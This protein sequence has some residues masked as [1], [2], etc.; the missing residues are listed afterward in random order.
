MHATINKQELLFALD[1]VVKTSTKHQTLPVLQCV[2]MEAKKGGG[3]TLTTNNLELGV[4]VSLSCTVDETFNVAVPALIFQQTINLVDD[5]DITLVLEKEVLKIKTKRGNTS[6]KPLPHDEFPKIPTLDSKKQS[7]NGKLLALC[8]K[9]AA[10]AVS[11]S[12]IKPE[13]GSVYLHQSKEHSVTAVATDS[14]RL[15][16]K[17]VSQK[18]L[19]LEHPILIPH[20]NALEIARILDTIEEDPVFMVSENQCALLFSSKNNKT[21]YVTSRLTEGSFPDYKQIIPKEY[22]THATILKNDLLHALK[23]TN[24][25]TNKFLQVGVALDPKKGT[26]TLSADNGE[27]GT[28]NETIK[29]DISGSDLALSFNQRYLIEPLQ[30]FSDDSLTLHFAGVG[31]PMVMEGVNE[32]SLRYL[33]M[34]MNR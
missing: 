31:R 27:V 13:L 20:K 2:L 28:T 3:L 9:T 6:I 4:S 26:L 30:H 22:T 32:T 16:E 11:Q 17:T 29:A 34:P 14:F 21:I 12:S 24:I 15:V 33:V 23:T 5:S 1:L 7:V 19:V 25:F 8:I 10:F 18:S